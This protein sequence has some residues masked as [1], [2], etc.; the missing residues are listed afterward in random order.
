MALQA[1]RPRPRLG[2]VDRRFK[3]RLSVVLGLP[4]RGLT[5][6]RPKSGEPEDARPDLA[7]RNRKPDVGSTA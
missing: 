4:F 1:Q 5:P 7:H 3:H 2:S 6:G